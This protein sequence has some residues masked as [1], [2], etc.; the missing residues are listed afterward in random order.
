MRSN[1][2]LVSC[3]RHE[4]ETKMSLNESSFQQLICPAKQSVGV[5]NWQSKNSGYVT[6]EHQ[7]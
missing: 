1:L 4:N 5:A 6:Q 7:D 3:I 2:E